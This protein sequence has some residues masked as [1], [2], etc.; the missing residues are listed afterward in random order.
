MA[1]RIALLGDQ[2]LSA[3]ADGIAAELYQAERSIISASRRLQKA[4]TR[5]S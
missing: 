4:S 5:R 2:M 3:K 1:K